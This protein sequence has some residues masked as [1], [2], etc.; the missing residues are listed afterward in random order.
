MERDLA[1]RAPT[2]DDRALFFRV[3]AST[4]AEE[5]AMMPLAPPQ[6]EALLAMQFEARERDYTARH[7]ASERF[8]VERRG[9]PVGTLWLDRTDHEIRVLDVA[10]LPEHRNQGLGTELLS[11]LVREARDRR[12]PL[13]LSVLAHGPARRL[14][15]RLGFEA[16]GEASLY[17]SMEIA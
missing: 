12:L 5:L 11:S 15:E 8:V 1:L 6:K 4:R 7:R 13:R 14:Y 2:T 16:V 3:F 10:L 17:I 9:E